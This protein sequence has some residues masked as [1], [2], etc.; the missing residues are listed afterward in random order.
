[1]WHNG[2]VLVQ[3]A[4]LA[5]LLLNTISLR[6][7]MQVVVVDIL[8]PLP[9][10][11]TGNSN[12]LVAGDYF[13]KW[14]EAYAIPNQEADTV[15]RIRV[16][17][18][19]CWFSLPEQLHPDQGKQFESAVI[20]EICNLLGI[21]KTR[22]SPYHPQC[23]GLVERSNRMLLDMLATTTRSHQLFKVC[24]AYN[25]SVH[26]STGYTPFFLMF[27]RQAKL[28]IDLMYGVNTG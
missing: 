10:S 15:A 14:L 5:N 8:G 16:D 22:T 25:M 6:F 27:V 13:M 7:P 26:A 17:Q 23:D 20:Q 9:E 28:P 12:I 3:C 21:K 11:S 19:F 2:S 24:M 4:P 1:M 18:M